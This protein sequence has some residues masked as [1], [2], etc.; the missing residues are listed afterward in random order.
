MSRIS[1]V[2]VILI[3]CLMNF[4]CASR[5]RQAT[6]ED[7][8]IYYAAYDAFLP[9]T[10]DEKKNEKTVRVDWAVLYSD[11]EVVDYSLPKDK[12]SAMKRSNSRVQKKK[13]HSCWKILQLLLYFPLQQ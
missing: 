9:V 13:S 2:S 4:S 7:Q 3:M 12:E 6:N 10:F 8:Y 5:V 11:E 1:T